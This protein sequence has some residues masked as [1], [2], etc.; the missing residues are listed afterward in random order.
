MRRK[1]RTNSLPEK[2]LRLVLVQNNAGADVARNLA[3]I[4]ARLRKNADCDLAVLPEVFAM[5]GDDNNCRAV[6]ERIPGPLTEHIAQLAKHLAIWI[7]AGSIIEKSGHRFYNTSLLFNRQGRLVAGYRKIHLFEARLDNGQTVR[8]SAVYTAGRQPALADIEGW[9]C[10]MSICYDLRFP[11]LFRYY[12]ARGATLFFAPANFT[13]KTGQAHWHTLV[14]ARAIENQ[15]FI[16][17]PNQCGINR[18]TG[19]ASYGHSLIIDPWGSI[20]AEAGANAT[21]LNAVL[22]PAT[23]A[24]ARRRMPALRHMRAAINF[25]N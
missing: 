20:L 16:I 9:R 25:N 21:T 14:R 18:R 2:P 15:S 1:I 3:Q 23:L 11:E 5:R 4:E 19:V 24:L 7:L 12:A 17:A 8:E 10:G 13:Q 6:A 22:E